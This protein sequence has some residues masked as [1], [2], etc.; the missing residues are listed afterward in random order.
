MDS[1]EIAEATEVEVVDHEEDHDHPSDVQKVDLV[2]AILGQ[3]RPG[4]E[5]SDFSYQFQF[6][7]LF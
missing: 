3:R 1:S 4:Y 5:W 6:S 7:F 2:S